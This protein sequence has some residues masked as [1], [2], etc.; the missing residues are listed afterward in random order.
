[1]NIP[2]SR[3]GQSET[4]GL[5]LD[6]RD[7]SETRGLAGCVVAKSLLHE[8]VQLPLACIL[9]DL[10]IPRRPVEVTLRFILFDL[11]HTRIV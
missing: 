8:G 10:A 2:R 7:E 9:F 3:E 11:G 6:S 4:L 1:M 5:R